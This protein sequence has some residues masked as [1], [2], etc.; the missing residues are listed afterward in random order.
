MTLRVAVLRPEPGNAATCARVAAHGLEVVALPMFAVAAIDWT[1]PDPRDHDALLLTSAN[2]VRTAG[3][4]LGRFAH[5]PVLAVGEATAA[6]AR[7]AGL[8]VKMAGAGDAASLIA[9]ISEEPF[10]HVLHLGGRE[11]TVRIGTVVTRSIAVYAS[12]PVPIDAATLRRLAGCVAL[13]HSA[14][15]AARLGALL[16]NAA[17]DR[18]DLT[19]AAI[20]AAVAEAA[21]IGWRSV[22]I[23]TAPNDAALLDAV[24]EQLSR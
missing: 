18:S 7:A 5:L 6:A 12:D 22:A 11:T 24:T 13:L 9:A 17:I 23:A 10:S 21:G 2:T 16:D 8:D 15:A 14:R 4:G 20:S 19:I 1:P 3:E